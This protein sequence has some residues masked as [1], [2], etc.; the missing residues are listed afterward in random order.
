MH[1]WTQ[2]GRE[3]TIRC[4]KIEPK[5]TKVHPKK[6]QKMAHLWSTT[7]LGGR[8]GKVS[9]VKYV[10]P[11][12]KKFFGICPNLVVLCSVFEKHKTPSSYIVLF[13]EKTIL[14]K[15]LFNKNCLQ[16]KMKKSFIKFSRNFRIRIFD[17]DSIFPDF[18]DFF[19]VFW[20]LND[21]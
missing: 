12:N 9:Y 4:L 10:Y 15:N 20:I 2:Y 18:P 19:R 6:N 17:P 21:I 14:G 13:E 5:S 11:S 3:T 8:C 16:L 7:C 1:L